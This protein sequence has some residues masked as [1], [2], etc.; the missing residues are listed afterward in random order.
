VLAP[1][2]LHAFY[3]RIK[4]RRGYGKAIVATARK[5]AILFRCMLMIRHSLTT[6]PE[7]CF[8]QETGKR[9]HEPLP[10]LRLD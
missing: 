2:P 6:C 9:L 1:G 5:L 4:A 3:E 8:T 10:D 7:S